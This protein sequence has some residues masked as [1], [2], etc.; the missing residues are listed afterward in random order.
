MLFATDFVLKKRKSQVYAPESIAPG[1]HGTLIFIAFFPL[2]KSSFLAEKVGNT[3]CMKPLKNTVALGLAVL[4][5]GSSTVAHAEIATA[6]P[7]MRFDFLDVSNVP[8]ALFI[9]AAIFVYICNR[10]RVMIHARGRRRTDAP[11][12]SG[13]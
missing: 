8:L 9:V 13:R 4:L 12:D 2:Q 1:R 3:G 10:P 7:S 6:T 5:P 11:R